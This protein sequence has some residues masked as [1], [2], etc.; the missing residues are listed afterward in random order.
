MLEARVIPGLDSVNMDK[1]DRIKS[2]RT[3]TNESSSGGVAGQLENSHPPGK[4]GK[5]GRKKEREKDR[6]REK[7]RECKAG[8]TG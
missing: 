2:S 8:S 4:R 6:E 1:K 5:K 3:V 7:G